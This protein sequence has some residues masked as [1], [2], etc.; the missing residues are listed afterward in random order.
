MRPISKTLLV[1]FLCLFAGI[2]TATAQTITGAFTGTLTDQTGA[3]VP[4]VKVVATNTG[5]NLQYTATTNDS[6]VYNLLFLPVGDYSMTAEATGFK[7]AQLG[8]FKL[9]VNQVARVDVKMEVGDATQSV[10]VEGAAPV[11][12]TE[13]TQTGDSLSAAKLTSLPLNGRNFAALTL[14]VP[15]AIS[16]NPKGLST[17]QRFQARPYVN[18]NREQT[19]NFMLDGVDVNDSMD[20]RIGYQPN[21]DALEEVKVLTGNMGADYGN[22]GAASVMLSI[23]SGTNQF[24]GSAFEFLRNNKLDANGFFRNRVESTATRQAFKR[25][26]FGGTLGGPIK[27]NKAFFFVD[28]EGTLQRL[29]GNA[30]ANVAPA[31]WRNGDLSSISTPIIDPLTKT[32][33]NPAGVAFDGNRIPTS[34]ITN[35]FARKLFSDQSLYPLPNQA[36]TGP[37]GITGNYGGV[38]TDTINNHQADAKVDLRPTDNDSISGRWSISRYEQFGS[39]LATNAPIFGA[40]MRGGQTGPTMSAVINWNRTI[41]PS[42]VNEARVAYSR[43]GID[44]N[45]IDWSGLLGANGNQ[46]FGIPGG[47]PIPGLSFVGNAGAGLN[48][49]T[50]FGSA[51]SIGSTVDNKFIYYDNLTWQK[52]KHLLKMGGQFIRTQQ[53]RYYAG[54]NGAL[55]TFSYTGTYTGLDYADFL[56]DN[57]ASKGRGSVTGKWGH[58]SWRSAL[59]FQDD[60]RLTSTFTLN[61]GLRWEYMQPIYEVADRQVNVNTATGQLLYAGQNGSN[62]A[63]YNGYWKQFMPRVGFAWTLNNKTVVRAGYAYTSFMEGTGAN[64][65]LPLNPPFFV[66]SNLTYGAAPGA[67]GVGFNDVV[68]QNVTLDSPRPPG[69]ITTSLQGRAWDLN[70]R[71]QTTQQLNL[72]IERQID[73]STSAS[74]GFVAQRGRHLVAPHEANQPI[75]PGANPDT[76]R[77]LYNVLPNLGNIALTDASATMDYTSLQAALRRRFAAG[78]EFQASYTLSKTLTDNLGYYGSGFTAG[79]GAYWQNAYDRLG[80]RGPAFFDARHNFTI[81]G[82]YQLPF[83]V[84][85]KHTFGKKGMDLLLGGWGVNYFLNAH[86][87]FP[88]TIQ[89]AGNAGGQL[90]RGT[91]RANRYRTLQ[92]GNRTVDDWFGLFPDP[93][94]PRVS[95]FC[96]VGIDNGTCA[97]GQAAADS[98]GNTGIGTERMPSYFSMDLSVGKRV[99]ITERQYVEFRAESFNL[100]NHVSWAA[101]GRSISNIGAFGAIT[102][103]VQAPRN[104]Q[105]ALKYIF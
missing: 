85:R 68:T 53:N 35:P 37:Q 90:V 70:L 19:N 71:P 36:G 23:K 103:Q 12:Q 32:A 26:I 62:R 13:S 104:I 6:G 57:L 33:A 3:V 39:N 64:L 97:Y 21:V 55:G 44:D 38:N 74:V 49:L 73:N 86:T 91:L 99:N 65:R 16:P 47:Q 76:R 20:N 22:A 7:K 80:N 66:E 60:I 50:G 18:G 63:L 10:N 58:R 51:A 81:G 93:N 102:D 72:T 8:P 14:M 82:L 40:T 11:L 1:A 105:F 87:G 31:T 79:E 48:G 88:I 59:F 101:P 45:V 2:L 89:S 84:G 95:P 27:K 43:I 100:L 15:G 94:V 77:P 4:N 17:S 78:L 34:R 52:G 67:I 41:S 25:N 54:N 75:G 30:S 61:L 92:T 83:G 69:V 5:T 28:Y 29:S 24:H 56:L 42:V 46:A 98:F 96:G 9:E